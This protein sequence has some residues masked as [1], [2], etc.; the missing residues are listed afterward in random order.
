VRLPLA[1]AYQALGRQEEARRTFETY[2]RFSD[3][4]RE[5]MHLERRWRRTPDSMEL[6]L[7]M[8]RVHE[9]YRRPDLALKYYQRA[10]KLRPD[11]ERTAHVRALERQIQAVEGRLSR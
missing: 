10:Q 6:L 4:R 2:R 9:R 1:Q 8:A 7:R 5:L 3:Y 11:P